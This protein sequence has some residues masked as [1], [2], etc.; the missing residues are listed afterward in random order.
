MV[1]IIRFITH[2][3][4]TPI[5]LLL[6]LLCVLVIA[7]VFPLLTPIMVSELIYSAGNE[8]YLYIAYAIDR[9]GNRIE[10]KIFGSSDT[11][12]ELLATYFMLSLA[13]I[14]LLAFSLSR[15]LN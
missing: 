9:F 14:I 6:L 10:R 4:F 5:M 3:I 8:D 7:L 11:S 15:I 13:W 2:Y 12:I 1:K